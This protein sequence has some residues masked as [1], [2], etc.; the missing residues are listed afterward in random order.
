MSDTDG[1]TPE[2]FVAHRIVRQAVERNLEIIGEAAKGVSDAALARVPGVDWRG[3]RGVRDV[4]IHGYFRVDPTIV[5]NIVQTDCSRI[6]ANL[7]G[8]LE[9]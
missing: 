1:M 4:L 9:A 2:S 8:V 6:A 5:W 3:L 7:P